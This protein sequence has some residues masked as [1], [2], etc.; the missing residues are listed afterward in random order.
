[1]VLNKALLQTQFLGMS[2]INLV[3]ILFQ[4]LANSFKQIVLEYNV[5]DWGKNEN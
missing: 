4:I 3:R 2:Y 5:G 1:M